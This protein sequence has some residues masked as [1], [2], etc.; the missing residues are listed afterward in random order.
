[1]KAEFRQR[2]REEAKRHSAEERAA[3]SRAICD[4][5]RAQGIW[6]NAKSVLL[7]VP[8]VNEPDISPLM[9]DGKRVSLPA[10]NAGL[11]AYEPRAIGGEKDLVPGQF[12]IR[13]PAPNCPVTDSGTLDLV[14]APGVAFALDGGRGKGY[15]DR[16]LAQ[17]K[18]A[19]IGVCFDWQML[20]TIPRDS[21]DVSMDYVVTQNRWMG[22]FNVEKPQ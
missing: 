19:K 18:A 9:N 15:Y 17:V 16:L 3:A 4:R 7:F 21:H 2:M 6:R 12:G 14:L 22:P 13:E 1:M 10:Y 5:I 8:T 11:A 20:P